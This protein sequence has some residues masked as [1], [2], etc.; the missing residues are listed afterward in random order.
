VVVIAAPGSKKI[1]APILLL[2]FLRKMCNKQI[3][4]HGKPTPVSGGVR[5]SGK[6]SFCSGVDNAAPAGR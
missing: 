2:K 1:L 6:W 3:L 5:V 4:P